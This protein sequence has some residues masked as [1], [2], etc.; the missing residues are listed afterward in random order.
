MLGNKLVLLGLVKSAHGIKGHVVIEVFTNHAKDIFNFNLVDQALNTIVLKLIYQKKKL[1]ICS[2]NNVCSRN[3]AEKM[4]GLQIFCFRYNLPQPNTDEFYIYDLKNLKV[5]KKDL[6]IVGKIKEV[7]DFGA[8]GLIELEL[9]N[10][11]IET[12]PFNKEIFPIVNKDY[13]MINARYLS[14]I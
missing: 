3:A 14:I 6:T 10:G 2:I 9:L 1:L 11:K 13:M 7:Y 4:R 5:V 12:F 8:G